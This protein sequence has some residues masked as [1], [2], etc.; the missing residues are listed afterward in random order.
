MCDL[1]YRA[2]SRRED[3]GIV[4]G[5]GSIPKSSRVGALYPD[6]AVDGINPALPIRRSRP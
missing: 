4:Y 2:L 3:S 5:L 6:T 1:G